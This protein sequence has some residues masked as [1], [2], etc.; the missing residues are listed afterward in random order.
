MCKCDTNVILQNNN[1]FH[2]PTRT[3][4]ENVNY[5]NVRPNEQ[6]YMMENMVFPVIYSAV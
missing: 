2:A 1:N 4:L 6:T 3:K 5:L